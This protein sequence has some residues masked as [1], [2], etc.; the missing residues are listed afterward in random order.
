MVEDWPSGCSF[1]V[2]LAGGPLGASPATLLVRWR[3]AG[4]LAGRLGVTDTFGGPLLGVDSFDGGAGPLPVDPLSGVVG[5]GAEGPLGVGDLVAAPILL[6]L[7][8]GVAPGP[9]ASRQ[10]RHRPERLQDIAGPVVLERHAVARR[11]QARARTTCRYC[12]PR[13]ALASSHPSRRC[14]CWRS[15]RSRS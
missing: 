1:L 4:A 13:C 8:D 6:D 2:G 9:P 15:S 12:G 7:G 5:L 3:L 11:C 10:R 14:W